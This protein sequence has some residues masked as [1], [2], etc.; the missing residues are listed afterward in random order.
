MGELTEYRP[1]LSRHQEALMRKELKRLAAGNGF[2]T[3]A[4]P[5]NHTEKAALQ[6]ASERD[7]GA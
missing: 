4:Y 6:D 3:A 7:H 2:R 1:L 5:D